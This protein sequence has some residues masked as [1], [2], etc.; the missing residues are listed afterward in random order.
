MMPPSTKERD[1][2]VVVRQYNHQPFY[3]LGVP[4]VPRGKGSFRTLLEDL[5][6]LAKNCVRVRGSSKEFHV[7]TRPTALQTRALDLLGVPHAS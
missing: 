2:A 6:T 3:E 4:F 5:G 1:D 7:L